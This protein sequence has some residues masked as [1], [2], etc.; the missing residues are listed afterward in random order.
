MWL[1]KEEQLEKPCTCGL[2]REEV[3]ACQ[4]VDHSY[5]ILLLKRIKDLACKNKQK[6]K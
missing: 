4:L 2:L 1:A 5:F 3:K 6:L